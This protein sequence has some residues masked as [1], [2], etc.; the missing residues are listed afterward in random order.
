V[1]S[2]QR[3]KLNNLI[4][5]TNE[6]LEETGMLLNEITTSEEARIKKIN[7]ALKETYGFT[8]VSEITTGKLNQLYTKIA[9]DLYNLKLNQATAQDPAYMQKVLVLEGLKMLKDK[10]I[11]QLS[12]TAIAGPGGRALDRVLSRLSQYV[13]RACEIG[14]DYEEA[15][16]DAMKAYA[17]QPYRFD[18]ELVEYELRKLSADCDPLGECS[19]GMMES[20]DLS[21]DL[22]FF[23]E[24]QGQGATV[25]SSKGDVHDYYD[26]AEEARQVAGELNAKYGTVEEIAPVIGAVARGAGAA[27]KGIAKGVGKVAKGV[28]KEMAA[29]AGAAM[30]DRAMDSMEEEQELDEVNRDR[31]AEMDWVQGI[32]KEKGIGDDD[33][34]L[35][36]AEPE[37]DNSDDYFSYQ[38]KKSKRN[39]MKEGY[40]KELRKLLE[41]DTAQA[42]SLIA[43]KSFSQ[44][45][46]D[47]IE[48][49]GRLVN[50]DLPA[51]ADQM[52]DSH[53]AD[54]ATGFEDTVSNTLSSIMDQLR[55][56]K[57]EL[58]NSTASIADGGVPAMGN[59]MEDFSD[60]ELGGDMDMDAELDLDGDVDLDLDGDVELGDEFGGEEVGDVE[61]P[62]GRAKK[63]SLRVL[64]NK[65]VEAQ[66]KLARLKAAQ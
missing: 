3:A 48:K 46:Q 41:A 52:R 50:E 11:K 55:D 27:A 26:S 39:E 64:K 14:D 28:G 16:K 19:M 42:E 53:G 58:D 29:G 45:L 54:V 44:E 5:T 22:S 62:L 20:E 47:M 59:D 57:Q 17:I 49:L 8:L 7:K 65:I 66:A 1:A 24:P 10:K 23:V 25:M 34:D 51:V 37:D 43:A 32:K 40:V 15:I 12:E 4:N 33:I 63:E 18:N 61:E 30:A 56:S 38:A 36:I 21:E 6:L 13:H 9:D 31:Y 2:E 60:E 35:S